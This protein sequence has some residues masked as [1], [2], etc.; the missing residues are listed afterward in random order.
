MSDIHQYQHHQEWLKKLMQYHLLHVTYFQKLIEEMGGVYSMPT[1]EPVGT[2]RT[3]EDVNRATVAELMNIECLEAAYFRGW[4][5]YEQMISTHSTLLNNLL[6]PDATG[7]QH[8]NQLRQHQEKQQPLPLNALVQLQGLGKPSLVSL[9]QQIQCQIYTLFALKE[10]LQKA[11]KE[12]PHSILQEVPQDTLQE[13]PQD[14]SQE[15]PQDASQEVMQVVSKEVMQGVSKEVMQEV[16]PYPQW[17]QQNPRQYRQSSCKSK[18]KLS[19]QHQW[20]KSTV[21]NIIPVQNYFADAQPLSMANKPTTSSA[22]VHQGE[23]MNHFPTM[24]KSM[25][26]HGYSLNIHKMVVKLLETS[27]SLRRLRRDGL[28]F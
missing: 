6:V 14:T 20:M 11:L 17:H 18:L 22:T 28:N 13:V 5:D 3:R 7:M 9:K 25:E 10:M 16:P 21:N 4:N 8:F 19:K 2:I 24:N 1:M 12:M 26:P 27:I 23:F 15:I